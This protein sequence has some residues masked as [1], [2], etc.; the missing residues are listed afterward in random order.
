MKSSEDLINIQSGAPI[1]PPREVSEVT[2]LIGF[3][4]AVLL[5]T[6]VFMLLIGGIG[7]GTILVPMAGTVFTTWLVSKF[8][9]IV[10]KALDN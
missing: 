3:A 7:F 1:R 10:G 4:I 8:I 6:F 5:N 9:I 2:L